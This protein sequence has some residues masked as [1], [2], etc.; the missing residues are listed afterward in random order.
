M[1]SLPTRRKGFVGA[2]IV[3]SDLLNCQPMRHLTTFAIAL[4]FLM[5]P[6][7][8]G[9]TGKDDV[10]DA[11]RSAK[12]AAKDAGQATKKTAK[13]AVHKVKKGTKK[14]VNKSAKKAAEGAEKVEKKTK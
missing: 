5:A 2:A 1:P 7:L 10:K 3:A 12:Q 4:S 11:G 14:E 8:F 6:S 13:K 9:Q